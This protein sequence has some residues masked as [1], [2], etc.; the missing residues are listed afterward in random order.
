MTPEG[1]LLPNADIP[2]FPFE[3]QIHLETLFYHGPDP[4]FLLPTH[5]PYSPPNM[6][7]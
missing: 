5:S 1:S 4:T 6:S 2:T 7:L 3:A